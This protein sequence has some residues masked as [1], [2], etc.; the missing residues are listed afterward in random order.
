[1]E[2]KVRAIDGIEQKSVQEVENELLEKHEQEVNSEVDSSTEQVNSEV[3]DNKVDA[4]NAQTTETQSSELSED[5]VL[6][7]I[8]KKYDKEITS[9]QDLFQAR[10][11]SEPLP[12]DV[13]TYLKYKKETGRGFEDFSKLNRDL[14]AVNPDKLLKEYLMA[15]EKGLD[16]EDIDALMEDYSYDE[17]LDDETAVKKIRLKKKKDIAKAKEYFESEKEKYRIPLES[18]GSSISEEDK[19]ALEDYKQYVQQATTYEE[20]AKR[21]TDWF[22]Q[23]T[24]EV[25]GSEFKG[26][27]FA[28]DEDKKVIY[29]PGD[30]NELKSAQENPANFIQKFLD[31]DGLLKDAVGYHKSLAI[32]MNPEKFAKF[33]Y[34]Q[35]KSVATEDVIR[36]TKNVNM[37]TRR[38]PEVTNKGGM[39]IRAV[40]PTSGKG[41]RIKSKK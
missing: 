3:D 21:K 9:V 33:F 15:T 30:A 23:K 32:A 19:K 40:N 38:A 17:E 22:M 24:N 6:S 4:E 14:D 1:M 13:A 31:E 34:E 41:L 37:T 36:Q 39:Q 18:S 27:E 10:E 29:S 26:F 20:E 16:E 12:E 2:L 25:F 8:K 28:I 7:F 35:G 5:D 11:E